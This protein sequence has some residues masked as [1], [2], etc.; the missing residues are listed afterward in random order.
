MAPTTVGIAAAAKAMQDEGLCGEGTDNK[1][2]ISGLGLPA[3][4]EAYTLNGCAPQFAL[5]SF[6]D[7]GYLTYYVSYM[8]ATGDL[9]GVEG[10]QFTAGR[11]GDYTIE[12]D[13]TRDAG[14]RVLM[15]PFSVYDASNV[16]DAA[17]TNAEATPEMTP[18]AT[19]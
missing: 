10:E 9:K 4:M 18:E 11:M 15:G 1:V 6:V 7:L 8:L 3:E 2:V 19:P 14:L 5:W 17:G 13:P 12:K 16:E